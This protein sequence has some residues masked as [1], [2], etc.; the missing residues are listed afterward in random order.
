MYLRFWSGKSLGFSIARLTV[1]VVG[2]FEGIWLSPLVRLAD[3]PELAEGGPE[4][5]RDM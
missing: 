5:S 1:L 3:H 4:G 2:F